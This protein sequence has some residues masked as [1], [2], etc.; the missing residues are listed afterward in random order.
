MEIN[1]KEAVSAIAAANNDF[2]KKLY[3]ELVNLT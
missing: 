1:N 3:N 2:T